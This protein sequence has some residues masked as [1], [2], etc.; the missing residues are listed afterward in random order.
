MSLKLKILLLSTGGSIGG[1]E[2]FVLNLAKSLLSKQYDV[3]VIPGG[4]IQKKNLQNNNISVAE[5]NITGRM[6]W[7]LLYEAGK[8]NTFLS[9]NRFDI[10]YCHS[11]GPAVMGGIIRFLRLRGAGHL[12]LFHNHG[13]GKLTYY[14][15]APFLNRLDLTVACSDFERIRPV[16]KGVNPSRIVR[17]H[18]GIDL[19][20][21]TFSVAEKAKFKKETY[22]KY[23]V[24]ANTL[25]IGYIG[26]L[27]PE[28]GCRILIPALREV[29]K[30][31]P[32]A[33]LFIV[34]DGVLRKSLE[35]DAV[36]YGVADRVVFTGFQRD[37]PRFFSTMDVLV[38][39]SESETFSLTV[40]QAMAIKLPVLASDVGG[41]PEQIRHH[42]SGL[43]FRKADLNDFSRQLKLLLESPALRDELSQRAYNILS[44]YFYEQRMIDQL[45]I[46]IQRLRKQQSC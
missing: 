10:I 18:T 34:G 21:W 24:R 4:T 14:W 31:I 40:L 13:L 6:P 44:H 20:K 15:I 29:L 42:Y 33:I 9:R 17:V 30:T 37:M 32:N 1:E 2:T 38:Q 19:E 5:L 39:P 3:T 11:A 27:S 41:T 7:T 8:L 46:N 35:Q 36:R 25:A 45:E 12:W 16:S 26:R 23:D 28:K 43:L 22:R